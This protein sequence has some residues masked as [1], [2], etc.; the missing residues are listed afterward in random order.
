MVIGDR[1]VL[2]LL[3]DSHEFGGLGQRG[4]NPSGVGGELDVADQFSAHVAQAVIAD[5]LSYFVEFYFRFKIF[6]VNHVELKIE[7][8][9]LKITCSKS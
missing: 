4:F 1:K 8:T 9:K 3:T 6:G 7:S 5:K 2:F